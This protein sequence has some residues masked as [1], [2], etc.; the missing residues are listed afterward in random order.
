MN[1][2]SRRSLVGALLCAAAAPAAAEPVTVGLGQL[3]P[4]LENYLKLPAAER[5]RFVLAYYLTLDGKPGGVK[6]SLVEGARRTPLPVGA[7]GGLQRLPTLAHFHAKAKAELDAP[8]GRK[9][10]LI[11]TV[12]PTL[13]P[14]AEMKAAELA[15]AL[16]QAAAGAKKAAGVLGL[17]M[18]KL[19]QVRFVG[20]Q[21]G[22]AVLT[23]GR[24]VALALVKG[25]PVYRPGAL[26]AAASL[27]FA[28][29]PRRIEIEAIPR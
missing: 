22:E 13:S 3:F 10:G 26:K 4:F 20:A 7:D 25:D 11:M 2:P 21:G 12:E 19:E 17:A 15:A 24:R 28:K 8:K 9:G 5:S 14:A 29:V 27:H 6:A 18:P 1:R 23:D 16:A